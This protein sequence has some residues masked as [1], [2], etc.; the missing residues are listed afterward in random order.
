M[1]DAFNLLKTVTDKENLEESDL[2]CQLL[3]KKLK[4]MNEPDRDEIMFK[5]DTLMYKSKSKHPS[6]RTNYVSSP[7]T[8]D[9]NSQQSPVSQNFP[10]SLAQNY[11]TQGENQSKSNQYPGTTS[12]QVRSNQPLTLL[13]AS[14]HFKA[15][16]DRKFKIVSQDIIQKAYTLSLP[17]EPYEPQNVETQQEQVYILPE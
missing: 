4:K 13:H 3:A 5:I 6:Y 9:Y 8:Y 15:E 11:T 12:N 7:S 2:F 16:D 17:N 1:D 10:S 14:P